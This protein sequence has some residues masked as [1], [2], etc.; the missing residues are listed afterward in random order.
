MVTDAKEAQSVLRLTAFLSTEI[1]G[2]PEPSWLRRAYEVCL[3][4]VGGAHPAGP[5]SL[6]AASSKEA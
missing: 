1:Q 2:L 3:D 6:D 4:Q 5:R